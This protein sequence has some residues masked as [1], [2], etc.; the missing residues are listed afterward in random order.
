MTRIER[1]AYPRVP[2]AVSLKELRESFTP[3]EDEMAWARTHTQ[4]DRH[5]LALVLWLTTASPPT[6]AAHTFATA[7]VRGGTAPCYRR[8]PARPRPPRHR[9]RLHPPT[10]RVHPRPHPGRPRVSPRPRQ[11][12]RRPR[13]HRRRDARRGPSP[14]RA[15]AE[16]ARDRRPPRHRHGQEEGP[17]SLPG[18]RAAHAPRARREGRRGGRRR[19]TALPAGHS[20]SSSAPGSRSPRIV[21]GARSGRTKL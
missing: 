20:S 13:R 15:G 5:L 18:D 9:P 11:G 7:L 3:G 17:A 21:P 19:L 4:P 8:R 10:E 14:A 6:S 12:H 2:R 1:T 16:P